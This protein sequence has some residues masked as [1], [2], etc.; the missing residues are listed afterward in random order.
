MINDSSMS[1]CQTLSVWLL[2]GEI[3][4]SDMNIVKSFT[5][6]QNPELGLII[7]NNN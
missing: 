4:S 7:K 6:H 5:I 1:N 3:P 2:D